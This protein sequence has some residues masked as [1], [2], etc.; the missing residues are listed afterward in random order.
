MQM[1]EV[2][3]SLSGLVRRDRIVV[4]NLVFQLHSKFTV[5][6]LIALCLLVTAIQYFGSPID[7][8]GDYTAVPQNIFNLY[9]WSATTYSLPSHWNGE[10]GFDMAYP[11]LGTSND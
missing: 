1:T 2:F 3:S 5:G 7:C 10:L 9:C 4:D 11:G 8:L 6:L